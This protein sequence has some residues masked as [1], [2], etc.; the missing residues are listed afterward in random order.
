VSFAARLLLAAV[1]FTLAAFLAV[2]YVLEK[3]DR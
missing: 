3:L 2:C 1:Y